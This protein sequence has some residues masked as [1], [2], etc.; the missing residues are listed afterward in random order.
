[1]KRK[2]RRSKSFKKL[3]LFSRKYWEIGFAILA[4]YAIANYVLPR[5]LK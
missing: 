1:M 2:K 4:A 3:K 5:F